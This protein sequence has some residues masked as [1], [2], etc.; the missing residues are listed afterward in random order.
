MTGAADNAIPT[1]RARP[2]AA[3]DHQHSKQHQQLVDAIGSSVDAKAG[4]VD[5]KCNGIRVGDLGNP[6]LREIRGCSVHV[7]FERVPL[8][9]PR[10]LGFEFWTGDVQRAVER[11]AARRPRVAL[12]TTDDRL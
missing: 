8:L 12:Y 2:P 5:C 9:G 6:R 10:E 4:K 11:R 3:F 7:G 1:A